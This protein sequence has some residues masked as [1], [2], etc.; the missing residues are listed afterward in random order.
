MRISDWSSD[1]CSSDLAGAL[2]AI[3]LDK[4]LE[5]VD[6]EDHRAA[7]G[8]RGLKTILDRRQ[9]VEGAELIE[10]EP[11]AQGA[12]TGERHE[13]VDG[14]VHPE[15]QQRPVHRQIDIFRGDEQDRSWLLLVGEPDWKS[16]RLKSS[17]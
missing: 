7:E 14:K 3:D 16:T 12:R 6:T 15:G 13:A 11:G 10:H 2:L 9:F 8:T 1:V 4:F 5:A 17:H